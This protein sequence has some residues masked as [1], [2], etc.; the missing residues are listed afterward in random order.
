[1]DSGN[2]IPNTWWVLPQHMLIYGIWDTWGFCAFHTL[3][4]FLTPKSY[5]VMVSLLCTDNG[6]MKRDLPTC[7]R[8]VDEVRDFGSDGSEPTLNTKRSLACPKGVSVS[9]SPTQGMVTL[10]QPCL[11]TMSVFS[12]H[13]SDACLVWM[14]HPDSALPSF[15]A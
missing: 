2:H 7:F 1:M 6:D 8:P 9:Y 12:K 14:H 4:S 3:A 15:L 11:P 13:H 10:P 5:I